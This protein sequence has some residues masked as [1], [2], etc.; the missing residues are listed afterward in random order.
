MPIEVVNGIRL[1]YEVAGSGEPLVLVHGSWGDHH[2]WDAFAPLLTDRF[3]VVRYDRRG[4]S[5]SECP[6]GQG[7]VTDDV[8]DLA[9]LIERL[10][11][12]PAHVVGNSFGAAISLRL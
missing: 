12:G 11:N 3:E 4:H 5:D 2:N 7:S 6:P 9:A 8:A 10:G 1:R